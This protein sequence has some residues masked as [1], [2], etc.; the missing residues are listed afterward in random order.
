MGGSEKQDLGSNPTYFDLGFV[1]IIDPG[2]LI[3]S[4]DPFE[5]YRYL[6]LILVESAPVRL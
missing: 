2:F 4:I 6:N 1:G 3:L 5:S